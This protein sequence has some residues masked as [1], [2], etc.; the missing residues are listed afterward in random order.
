MTPQESKI[1]DL[2]ALNE[3]LKFENERLKMEMEE[4]FTE[5]DRKQ[6]EKKNIMDTS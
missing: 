3:N 4:M 2:S 6:N 5:I 1:K